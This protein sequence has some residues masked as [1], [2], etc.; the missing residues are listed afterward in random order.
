MS[1]GLARGGASHKYTASEA[2]DEADRISYFSVSLGRRTSRAK[3]SLPNPYHMQNLLRSMVE[4]LG[5]DLEEVTGA[6]EERSRAVLVG[7]ES[8]S[9]Q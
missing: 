2:T 7:P 4:R 5:A 8:G 3:Y 1:G 6:D 9:A